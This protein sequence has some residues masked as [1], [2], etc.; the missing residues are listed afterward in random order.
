MCLYAIID[1]LICQFVFPQ[2]AHMT[3]A[4]ALDI[5]KTGANI[6]LTGEP[7]S[8][9]TFV[10]NAYVS[11]L[12]RAKVEVAVTASTGIA[13]THIGGRTIH[14]WSGIGI[15]KELT[16]WEIDRIASNEYVSKRIDRTRVLITDEISMLDGRTL[17]SIDRV[18]R[19]VRRNKEPFGGLQVVFVGDFFQLPP[20]ARESEPPAQFAFNSTA[21]REAKLLTCYLSEQHRQEDSA[22][23]TL[24]SSLRRNTVSKEEAK[25]LAARQTT[26]A[27]VI[28][29]GALKL[30]SHTIDVDRIN[31]EEL[32]RIAGEAKTFSMTTFGKKNLTDPLKKGCLSPEHLALK[33]GAAVMFTKNSQKGAYVNGTLGTVAVFDEDT[34][35]PIVVTRDSRHVLVE[36]A[37]WSIEEH[38]KIAAHIVQIPLRLA[39]AITV[40][41]SQGMSLDAA[42]VDLRRAFVEGQGYVAL[43]RV[44]TLAGL[45]LIGWNE[46]ALCVHPEVL[47]EDNRFRSASLEAEVEFGGLEA[48]ELASLHETFVKACGGVMPK[49]LD[50]KNTETSFVGESRLDR[51]REKYPRAYLPWHKEEDVRLM[52]LHVEGKKVNIIAEILERQ[53]SAIR[54]RLAKHE[55]I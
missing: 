3:Q 53:P 47:S 30:Y 28:P 33:V 41:K 38:G 42:L 14:S 43:S 17:S 10:T 50:R 11:Y 9:K 49:I 16:S 19:E 12:K 5:L 34:G 13:A 37:E 21:W 29:E 8:G 55:G 44:R 45:S 4:Q 36:P 18:C 25:T 2:K 22:F 32:L 40:H 31:D 46:M 52:E 23:L 48:I 1:F 27:G 20:V 51:L 7:G 39:W 24:L 6:F 15:K 26:E 54:S 35:Y